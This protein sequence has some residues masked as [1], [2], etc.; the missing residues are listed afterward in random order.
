MHESRLTLLKDLGTVVCGKTV[1]K[2]RRLGLYK[3]ECGNIIEVLTESVISGKT[4][5]CGCFKF[6]RIREASTT[7]GLSKSKIFKLWKSIRNRCYNKNS[8]KYRN[9]GGRGIKVCYEWNSNFIK[10]NEWCLEHGWRDGLQIDRIDNNGDYEPSNCHFITNV[11]NQAIG[12]KSI[13]NTNKSGYMGIH[14]SKQTKKWKSTIT[15]NRKQIHGGFFSSIDD[16][17][18]NRIEMEIFYFGE[19]K[20]NFHFLLTN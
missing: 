6:E 8:P 17:V 3:C 13:P 2:K 5:S 18:K 9:Y 16:A 10:F 4:K 19:Q 7:H 12:K 11:E 20:T 15:I 14:W 1:K